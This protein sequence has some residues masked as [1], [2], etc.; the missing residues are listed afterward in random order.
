MTRYLP[1]VLL[2]VL[3]LALPDTVLA[4]GNTEIINAGTGLGGT[5]DTKL[6]EIAGGIVT[7]MNIVLIMMTVISGMMI[8]F[9]LEDGKKF[10][11]QVMLGAGL[12]VNFGAFMFDVG[13]W[14]FAD[15][16]AATT[17]AVT[18]F[19]PELAKTSSEWNILGK[20]M[21]NYTQHIITPGAANILPYCLKLLVVLAIIQATWEITM[22]FASGDK[23][24]YMI[25][26]TLKTGFYMFLMVNWISLM[27]ALSDGFEMLGY[28]AGGNNAASASN[29]VGNNCDQIVKFSIDMVNAIWGE[30][31]FASLGILLISVC[32]L[33]AI[34]YCLFMTAL[35][36]FMARIEFYT[37]AL[38]TIPLLAFGVTE[39]FAF[40][41]EKAIGAMF[42]LAIKICVIAFIS[43]MA[44]PFIESFT[45]DFQSTKGFGSDVAIIL[46]AILACAIIY[47]LTKKI[48]ALVTGLLSGSPQLGGSSMVDMA[49]GA[50]GTVASA[51]RAAVTGGAALAGQYAAAKTAATA[52]GQEG[53]RGTLTQLG[54]NYAYSR[55]PV[56]AYRGAI[57]SFNE[58]LRDTSSVYRD[59]IKQTIAKQQKATKGGGSGGSGG[60][61]GAPA[62]NPGG[63]GTGGGA[64]PV[65]PMNLGSG[66]TGGGAN[67]APSGNPSSGGAGSGASPTP[68]PN[69][70]SGG[71]AGTSGGGA[72]TS[73]GNQGNNGS[74]P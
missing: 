5:F 45:K 10:M 29:I 32:G 13:F 41:T 51:G 33:V 9:G 56:Q 35:E 4:F 1:A 3:V 6:R 37:M 46:Q 68:P 73:S 26:M 17:N 7:A 71:A 48:P 21:D 70:G 23:I 59:E 53:L 39:K 60:G 61:T 54:R 44:V 27:G 22:K 8:S 11:W 15:K 16:Y 42:N 65:P 63:G 12:A 43:S 20:F 55:S 36:M 40:L 50:G 47:F 74:T 18:Y 66:G 64:S 24:Q 31:S 58:T 19:Q 25:Q 62:G 2:A 38:L 57:K 69:S 49:R 52:K 28:K 14:D 72:N 30:A 67:P 34:V